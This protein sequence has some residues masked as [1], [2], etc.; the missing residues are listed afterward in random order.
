MHEI[1]CGWLYSKALCSSR[2]FWLEYVS[3]VKNWIIY[4]KRKTA[5]CVVLKPPWDSCSAVLLMILCLK[6]SH[7]N[8]WL[9]AFEFL[10]PIWYMF[11]FVTIFVLSLLSPHFSVWRKAEWRLCPSAPFAPCHE[12]SR[13]RGFLRG[14]F[15]LITG[16]QH[17]NRQ[18]DFTWPQV[19]LLDFLGKEK[20]KSR[21]NENIVNTKSNIVKI[22]SRIPVPCLIFAV[23][24]P[25]QVA[26]DKILLTCVA[27]IMLSWVVL[28]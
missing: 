24:L 5:C 16:K 3:E 15:C 25:G 14:W 19:T 4:E 10:L 23:L 28:F 1:F 8:S 12:P 22:E 11:V 7:C 17:F 26:L 18:K 13:E 27:A 6:G 21:I 2:M 20:K 9:G